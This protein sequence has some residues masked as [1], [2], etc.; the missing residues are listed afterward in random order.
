[1]K[2][3]T[4]RLVAVLVAMA[5]LG[6]VDVPSAS[7]RTAWIPFGAAQGVLAPFESR[8]D[9]ASITFVNPERLRYSVTGS[10]PRARVYVE[11][12]C[13]RRDGSWSKRREKNDVVT[14][15]FTENVT[16]LFGPSKFE[17]CWVWVT[18]FP[19]TKK[20]DLV[21]MSITLEARYGEG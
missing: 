20:N 16:S 5:A 7:A 18:A 12:E 15:P 10:A 13:R 19:R 21:T 1:M 9:V 2:S 3:W 14:L 11:G 4:T 17:Y 6:V 8:L